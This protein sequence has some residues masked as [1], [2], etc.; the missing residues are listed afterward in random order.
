[1]LEGITFGEEEW[2]MEKGRMN[3]VSYK[4]GLVQDEGDVP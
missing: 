3:S 1:M 4:R 2:E